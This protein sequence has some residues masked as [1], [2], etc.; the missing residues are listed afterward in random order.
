MA[1]QGIETVGSLLSM[2]PQLAPA[3]RDEGIEEALL[4]GLR[5]TAEETGD[6]HFTLSCLATMR[7][8]AENGLFRTEDS[9]KQIMTFMT[10]DIKSPVPAVLTHCAWTLAHMARATEAEER[11]DVAPA[12]HLYM[13]AERTG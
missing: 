1:D 11:G 13:I 12:H 2:C 4:S 3:L 7:V 9:A 5:A 6:Q 10:E 8:C